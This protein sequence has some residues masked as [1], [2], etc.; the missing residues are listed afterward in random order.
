MQAGKKED[1]MKIIIASLG[2]I[3]RKKSI[4]NVSLRIILFV[5]TQT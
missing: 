5:E 2:N 1:R 4:L 3:Y